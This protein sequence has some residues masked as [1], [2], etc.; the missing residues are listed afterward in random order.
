MAI[1][2]VKVR[3][4]I[5]TASYSVSTPYIQ[6][7]DVTRTRGQAAV[8]SVGVKLPKDTKLSTEAITIYAGTADSLKK[9]FYGYIRRIRVQPAFDDP[10]FMLVKL[11]GADVLSRLENCRFTRREATSDKVW[12]MV[13]GVQRQSPPD[14]Y[15]KSVY[16]D[17]SAYSTAEMKDNSILGPKKHELKFGTATGGRPVGG[18][19]ILITELE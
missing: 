5:I 17:T 9:I 6:S 7:I 12:A 11:E 2:Y 13:T 3:A 15:I 8:F 18:I 10:N 4:Q 16:E 1:S 14:P 19:P